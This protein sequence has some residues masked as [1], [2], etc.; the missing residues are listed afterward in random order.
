MRV[1]GCCVVCSVPQLGGQQL[2]SSV[3]ELPAA[4]KQLWVSCC[5]VR[6]CT[7][8]HAGLNGGGL[9]ENAAVAIGGHVY[10]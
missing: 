10:M 8:V 9:I 4:G 5:V 7:R 6:D 1:G 2:A 3:G